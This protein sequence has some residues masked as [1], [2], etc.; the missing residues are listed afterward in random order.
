MPSTGFNGDFYRLTPGNINS[1]VPKATPGAYVLGHT[2]E[3]ALI[4]DYVGRSD[5]DLQE[6]LLQHADEKKYERFKFEVFGTVEEAFTQEC[7]LWHDF[8]EAQFLANETHPVPA[9]G[10]S[11]PCPVCQGQR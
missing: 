7:R 11:V 6:R 1:N 8:G 4:V 9:K 3:G 2:E 10:C 5:N